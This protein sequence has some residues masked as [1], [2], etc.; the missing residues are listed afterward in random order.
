MAH[1]L[2]GDRAVAPD[3]GD[4]R[5]EPVTVKG[6]GTVL[7]LEVRG[8]LAEVA[9]PAYLAVLLALAEEPAAVVC[10]VSG[11][12]GPAD[13][14]AV[15]LLASL[16]VEVEQWPGVPVA[17]VCPDRALREGLARRPDGRHL[18]IDL[19][20]APV[21]ARLLARQPTSVVRV[22]LEADPRSAGA[23]RG[24]VARACEEW[25]M[26]AVG[27]SATL[28]VSEL[29][30]NALPHAGSDVGLTVARCGSWVRVAVRDASSERPQAQPVEPSRPRGR[31]LLLVAT[32]ADA[33]G[34]LP[35]GDGGKVVWAV[36][37]G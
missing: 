18:M 23:A 30:T 17:V 10:D 8:P 14:D 22:S 25:G 15:A 31:G 2:P 12:T 1:N 6:A 21:L 16:G 32:V 37:H 36:L 7:V 5:L 19:Q 26:A 33:W 11:V 29:V 27:A 4:V 20:R 24:V 9:D 3:S 13:P 28:V 35:A 34:V